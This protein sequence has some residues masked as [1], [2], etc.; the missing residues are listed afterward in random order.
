MALKR[1]KMFLLDLFIA[2]L[3]LA[4]DQFTKW[5][6][7][8][9]LKDQV[10]IVL[11]PGVLEL[12][13]LENRGAAFGVLQ[14]QK[15]FFVIMTCLVLIFC[16]YALWRMPDEKKYRLLHIMGG[17]LIAGALGNFMDRLRLDYVV[18]FIYI[19]LID[20]P[21]FNVADMY[22]SFICVLGLILVFFG[23]FGEEDFSFLKLKKKQAV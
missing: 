20:F 16:L 14:N 18:D 23:R 1:K 12:R 5:L 2:L 13:Y 21:I 19:S 11:I 15:I 8:F 6:A 9:Y 7:V 3:G 10:P 4:L 22:V 17:I